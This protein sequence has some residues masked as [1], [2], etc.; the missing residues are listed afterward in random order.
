MGPST[1]P[2]SL[3][4][5]RF[6]AFWEAIRKG[7]DGQQT[8]TF[9]GPA[10]ASG[11]MGFQP[12]AEVEAWAAGVVNSAAAGADGQ[13]CDGARCESSAAAVPAAVVARGS[14]TA[15]GH[16]RKRGAGSVASAGAGGEAVW[17]GEE[18]TEPPEEAW[19][20]IEDLDESEEEE[21]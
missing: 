7:A 17:R 18:P 12:S 8:P 3:T 21:A 15:D 6:R 20:V 2:L 5:P 16:D 10:A 11:A 1:P 19:D 9:T 14:D 4:T 13:G